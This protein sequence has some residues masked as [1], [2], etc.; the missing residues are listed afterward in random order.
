MADKSAEEKLAQIRH[1]LELESE[2]EAGSNQNDA[3]E[4]VSIPTETQPEERGTQTLGSD[5]KMPSHENVP[6][7]G[8]LILGAF[9]QARVSRKSDWDQMTT[10]TLKS[11][12]LSLTNHTFREEDYGVGTL[13]EFI[14]RHSDLVSLDT[15]VAHPI[16]KLLNAGQDSGR[17]I[18]RPNESRP[19]RI[20]SDLWQ[21][22]LDRSSGETYSWDPDTAQVKTDQPLNLD[23]IL[24]T[25]DEDVDRTW[26][27]D[28]IGRLAGEVQISTSDEHQL[29]SW[30]NDLLPTYRLPSHLIPRW[31]IFL[32]SNVVALLSDW[33][34]QSGL[35][36][37][38]DF[39]ITRVSRTR[40]GD[41]DTERV[42][43]LVLAVVKEMNGQ[44]LSNLILPPRAILRATRSRRNV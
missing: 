41:V 29:K 23:L 1:L 6:D 39:Y 22:V 5:E 8:A 19:V 40:H 20:R 36:P 32:T 3:T 26:R 16:V 2:E 43:Q 30:S 25:V 9:Q 34:K 13:T 11:R 14:R 44:E 12:M 7:G 38:K 10:A 37:P 24:P 15:S 33:F 4:D 27:R 42:R 17:T 18:S 21:A 35:E 31:N 28:F